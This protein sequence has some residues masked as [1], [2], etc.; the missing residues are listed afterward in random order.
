M[1]VCE[2]LGLPL[3]PPRPTIDRLF[4]ARRGL[5][6]NH[7]RVHGRCVECCGRLIDRRVQEPVIDVINIDKIT[8]D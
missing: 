6:G 7:C 8:I 2:V 5:A 4:T 3:D 1:D